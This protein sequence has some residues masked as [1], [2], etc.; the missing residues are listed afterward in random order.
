M[1]YVYKF[2][3]LFLGLLFFGS[4]ASY[5]P[6]KNGLTQVLLQ[7]TET[8]GQLAKKIPTAQN[9]ALTKAF[10]ELEAKQEEL[11]PMLEQCNKKY[12]LTAE[13]VTSLSQTQKTLERLHGNFDTVRDKVFVLTAIYKDYDAKMQTIKNTAKNDA[14]TKIKVIINSNEEEGFFVFGKLSY[15]QGQDIKRFRFNQPTQNAI[16]DFVPGYYLF[17]LEKEDRVGEPELHLIMSNSGEEEK[18][19]VLKAPK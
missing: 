13:Y 14:T 12:A 6:K 18:Q 1:Q 19:L 11:F 3:M 2:N 9:Q 7:T 15:E 4:C 17:W 8:V 16:Q 10:T 5:A